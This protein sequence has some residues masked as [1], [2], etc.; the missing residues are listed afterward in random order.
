MHYSPSMRSARPLVLAL[1]SMLCLAAGVVVA[2]PAQAD[3]CGVSLINIKHNQ[4]YS[5]YFHGPTWEVIGSSPTTLS[6]TNAL[7]YNNSFSATVTLNAQIVSA[8][9]GF[10]VGKTITTQT[11]ATFP[12]PAD[13]HRWVLQ[14]GTVD[15]L[16]TFDVKS[17]CGGVIGQGHATETGPITVRHFQLETGGYS[18]P[19]QGARPRPSL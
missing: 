14:A 10:I 13:A 4:R 11:G 3:D 17:N 1:C 6:F 7:A 18:A 9:L 16:V 12:V 2:P 15:D 8:A 5:N 19:G